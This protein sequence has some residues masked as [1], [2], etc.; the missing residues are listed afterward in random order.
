[1]PILTRVITYLSYGVMK[2][3]SLTTKL[4]IV[5]DAL[6]RTA[7]RTLLDDSL[8]VYRHIKAD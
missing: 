3:S 2:Q 4:R 1:M 6:A 5:F 7:I 8:M